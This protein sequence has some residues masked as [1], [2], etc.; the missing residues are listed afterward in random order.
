MEK[1]IRR[2]IE[3]K[4][5]KTLV[6]TENREVKEKV[7]SL[8]SKVK[9][10]EDAEKFLRKNNKNEK[11]IEVLLIETKEELFGMTEREFINNGSLFEERNKENRNMITKNIVTKV[12][13]VLVMTSDR[14]IRET[15]LTGVE[16][17]KQARKG[18]SSTE[19]FIEI[20]EI[21]EDTKLYGMTKEKFSEIARPMV[22]EFH[23]KQ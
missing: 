1:I 6:M 21:T 23:F 14:K 11:I 2:T 13:R 12:A 18:L 15:F 7:F 10:I 4:E 8:P 20:I 5:A 19:K 3:E 17:E 22:D 16:N 9:T